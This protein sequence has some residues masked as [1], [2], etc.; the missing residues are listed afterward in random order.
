MSRSGPKALTANVFSKL[1]METL[2]I[3]VHCVDSCGY[4]IPATLS[5]KSIGRSAI[6][7]LKASMSSWEVTSSLE[8][9]QPSSMMGAP[10]SMSVAMTL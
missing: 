5:S 1:V 9:S 2:S 6:C 7:S 8:V 3:V 10:I 4:M